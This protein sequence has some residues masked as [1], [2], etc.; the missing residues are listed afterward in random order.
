MYSP[1]LPS[2]SLSLSLSL[3]FVIFAAYKNHLSWWYKFTFIFRVLDF[4][5]WTSC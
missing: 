4:Q 3:I 2:L 5:T 1:P